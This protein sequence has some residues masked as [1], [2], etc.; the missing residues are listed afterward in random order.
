MRLIHPSVIGHFDAKGGRQAIY[1]LDLQPNSKRLATGGGDCH[2]RLWDMDLIL[3]D[4]PPENLQDC[5]LA[6][7]TTHENSV[8]IVRWDPSGTLLA[9][10]GA[11]NYILVHKQSTYRVSSN[12]SGD[13]SQQK[14]HWIRCYMLQGHRMDVLDMSWGQHFT[15]ATCSADNLVL[16]WDLS[17]DNYN[18]SGGNN[19]VQSPVHILK[20][21]KSHVKGVSFDPQYKYLASYSADHVL[22]IWDVDSAYTLTH[23]VNV[24]DLANGS[25]ASNTPSAPPSSLLFM[26]L[27]WSPDG[28]FLSVPSITKQTR[29]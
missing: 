14:E 13:S 2:V 15:L 24:F 28:L 16:I 8:N 10:A 12:L 1:S 25:I 19:I 3:A 27:A 21:H 7:L 11:D 6:S 4:P 18:T 29:E 22:C 9:S 20:G 23:T 5:L 17:D 26:R